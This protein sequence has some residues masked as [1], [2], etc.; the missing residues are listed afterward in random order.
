MTT[1][2]LDGKPASSAANALALHAQHLYRT[3]GARIV[4][5]VELAHVERTEP[6]P[7]EDKDPAVKLRITHLEIADPEQ[8]EALRQAQRAL[9][10]QRTARG[11]FDEDGQVELSEATLRLTAGQIAS[12]DAARLRIALAHWSEQARRV[13]AIPEITV[14]EMRHELD[15]ISQG[16][17][18]ALNANR[19]S[20]E[21]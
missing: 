8:E 1:I 12:I 18:A 13:L 20:D 6:A 19:E 10:L 11:T 9:Y 4:G 15:T 7:E 2:K 5:V 16:L 17:Y 21:G 14:S 3:P